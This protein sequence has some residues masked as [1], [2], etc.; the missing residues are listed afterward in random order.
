M[1]NKFV[2]LIVAAILFVSVVGCSFYNPLAGSSDAP[3][4]TESKQTPT[5]DKTLAEKAID[6]T[7]G[8]ESTGVPECDELLDS[9]SAQSK[10]QNDDYV[11]K[12]TREFFLNR[13]RE[14]VR[15]SIE[16]NKSDKTE[17]AKNCL[18]YKKQ[19]EKFKAEEDSKK[20]EK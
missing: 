12:A 9:I 20:A 8:G 10:N 6:A 3:K 5:E 18:D 13:I 4:N 17:M 1:K 11:S 19:L 2:L 7:V 14:S 16:E 15:K